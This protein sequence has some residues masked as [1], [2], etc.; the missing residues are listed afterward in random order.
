VAEAKLSLAVDAK[1]AVSGVKD[2]GDALSD[3]VDEMERVAKEGDATERALIDNAR[4]ISKAYKAEGKDAGRGLSKGIKEGTDEAKKEVA[5]SGREAA[6]SFG[7]GF[8]DVAD[9]AQESLANALGGFGPIGAAAGIAVAA[10]LGAALAGASAAQEKLAD[11]RER[12]AELAETLYENKGKLPIEDAISRVFELVTSERS[13]GNI[14]EGFLNDFI[15]LGTN[16]DAVKR[17]AGLAKA[18]VSDFVRGLS[19]AD[20]D[21]SRKALESVEKAIDAVHEQART[22]LNF[23]NGVAISQL[24]ALKGQL[25]TTI[26][27]AELADEALRNVGASG[28]P[29]QAEYIA[30]VTAIGDAWTDAMTDASGYVTEAEGVTTFDWS[31]YLAD[32]ESTLAAAN[33]YKRRILTV[34]TDIRTEAEN[35]FRTQGAKGASAYLT[36]YEGASASDRS[37]F[38]AAAK[39][40]G[41]AAGKAQGEAGAK[42]AEQAAQAKA[43]GWGPLKMTVKPSI[44]DAQIRLYKPPTV[45]V[46]G[47]IVKPGTRQP[48]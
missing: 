24:E 21:A 11:T 16:M 41:E 47:V 44:D 3:V 19:G 2:F 31:A 37:R 29:G 30:Q 1:K 8:D 18:P 4:D 6:A 5:S 12:A 28:L 17:A 46:P 27:G 25:E 39:A 36:A 42:A 35:I 26:G 45:Y 32:A 22:E 9:F 43:Q 40:N 48:I 14:L 10:A 33:D 34:P 38:V 15:D 20:L 7:G 23:D 13:A